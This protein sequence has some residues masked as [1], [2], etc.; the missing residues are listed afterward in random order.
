MKIEWGF[1]LQPYSLVVGVSGEWHYYAN[2]SRRCWA[3]RLYIFP[4][5]FIVLTKNREVLMEDHS[6]MKLNP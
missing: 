6:W 3:Y 1:Q 2:D 5:R 4:F